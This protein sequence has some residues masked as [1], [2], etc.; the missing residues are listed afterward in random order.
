[1]KMDEFLIDYIFD[2]LGLYESAIKYTK[3]LEIVLQ[4]LRDNKLYANGKKSEFGL[5]K[6]ELLGHFMIGLG[7]KPNEK[8]IEAIKK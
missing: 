2:I 7:I 8:K 5:I 6:I 4:I 1:V 3:H